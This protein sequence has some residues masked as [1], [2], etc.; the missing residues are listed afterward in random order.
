MATLILRADL[1]RPLSNI[2]VD[3]NFTNLNTDKAELNSPVFTG[4]PSISSAITL[5]DNSSNIAT[6]AWVQSEF[7]QLSRPLVPKDNY[8]RQTFPSGSVRYDGIDLGSFSRRFANIYVG[9]GVFAADTIEIGTAELKGSTEGGVVLP[10]NTAIG[11]A[12]NVLPANLAS[13]ALDSGF[14]SSNIPSALRINFIYSGVTLQGS[15]LA[16]LY[17]DTDGKVKAISSSAANNDK[18]IGYTSQSAT[19]GSSILV[20]ISGQLDGFSGLTTGLE[21]YLETDGSLSSTSSASNV[22]IGKALSTTKLFIYTTSTIDTYV[23]TQ[24]KLE[25]TDLSIG[26]NA[27]P[28]GEGSIQYNNTTGIF[29]FTPADTINNAS[30]TGVPTAATASEGTST[31]Q[32]ATT[33]FVSTAVSNLVGTAPTVLDTL[34]EISAAIAQ[35]GNFATTVAPKASPIFTGTPTAPTAAEGTNTTQLATTEFVSNSISG[36]ANLNN[37]ALT[38]TPTAPTAVAG[39]DTTQIATTAFVKTA[40]ALGGGASNMDGGVAQTTRNLATHHFDGGGANG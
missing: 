24:Q 16:P 2:E 40:V 12:E 31:T 21:Y 20:N 37:P 15:G 34:G 19:E 22:K 10:S 32:L 11:S 35:D 30:L 13:S 8:V 14:A 23:Q 7:V 25:L 18:F 5:S 39:T 33:Q 36:T 4:S 38:G 26:N 17:L 28:N 29:T 27:T 9:R 6:T 1:A 3:A